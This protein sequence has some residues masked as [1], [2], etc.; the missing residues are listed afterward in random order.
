MTT[1]T[2]QTTSTCI[3]CDNNPQEI[4]KFCTPC[5]EQMRDYESGWAT[6]WH[7]EDWQEALSAAQEVQG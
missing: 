5:F 4:G 7:G 3:E 6:A 1:T 2:N